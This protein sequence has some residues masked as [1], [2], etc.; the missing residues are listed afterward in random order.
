MLFAMTFAHLRPK[1]TLSD[2]GDIYKQN[3]IQVSRNTPWVGYPVF[4]GQRWGGSFH[5][6]ATASKFYNDG[7]LFLPVSVF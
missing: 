1:V 7:D 5:E 6:Y 2:W 4:R 3:E